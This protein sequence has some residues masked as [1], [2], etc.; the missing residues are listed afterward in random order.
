MRMALLTAQRM[1][2]DMMNDTK[3]KC[4]DMLAEAERQANEKRAGVTRDLTLEEQKL[5]AAR[6]ETAK[7]VTAAQKLVEQHSEFLS[8]VREMTGG[9][10]EK[11]AEPAHDEPVR[12]PEPEPGHAAP[13]AAE[14]AP[15]A[16][17]ESFVKDIMDTVGSGAD[18]DETRR[19]PDI[20]GL[21]QVSADD[22][23]T[24]RHEIEWTAEDEELT[25]RPKFKFDDLQFGTNYQEGK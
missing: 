6:S 5:S 20:S 15:T 18:L 17:I 1:S 16:D 8:K 7:F 3:K 10:A 22:S 23:P 2:D 14:P 24:K 19:V 11:A 4:E 21:Q 13:A 12:S 9:F 25:P